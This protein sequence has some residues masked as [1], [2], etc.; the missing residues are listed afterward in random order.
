MVSADEPHLR[1]RLLSATDA[2]TLAELARQRRVLA[3]A[4]SNAINVFNPELVLLGGFL[5]TLLASAPDQLA[6]TVQAHCIPASFAGTRIAAAGLGD[7]L[8]TIG[9]AELAFAR[10]LADPAAFSAN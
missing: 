1:A 4:L 8:L 3:A 6:A 7:D 9:A 2:A 10:L 5:A